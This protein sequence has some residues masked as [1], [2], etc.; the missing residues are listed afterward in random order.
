MFITL[1][2]LSR[3]IMHIFATYL[4]LNNLAITNDAILNIG[5]RPERRELKFRLPQINF[6]L[7]WII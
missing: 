3:K 4:T 7:I 2:F 1:F 5:S 6:L